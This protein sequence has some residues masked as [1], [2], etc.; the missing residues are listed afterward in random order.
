[1]L[2]YHAALVA[3]EP[4]TRAFLTAFDRLVRPGTRVL[5]VGSGTGVLAVAAAQRGAEVV[6]VERTEMIEYARVVAAANHVE[7]EWHNRDIVDLAD[8]AIAPVDVIVSE[9]IGNFLL[10]EDLIGV[11]AS[12]RRFLKPGG[13]LIPRRVRF[14]AAPG[15][16]RMI[17]DAIGFWKTPRFGIDFSPLAECLENS[18]FDELDRATSPIGPPI[19]FPALDLAVVEPG[20]YEVEGL[21]EI[22]AAA[23]VNS[24][25]VWWEAELA[26][27]VTLDLGP[28]VDWR[29][30]HWLRTVLPVPPRLVR[31]GEQIPFSLTYDPLAHPPLWSWSF[32]GASRSTFLSV[33]PTRERRVR[34]FGNGF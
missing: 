31:E 7:I 25:L 29:K 14:V 33:P 4:R 12:A 11:F 30:L 9:M 28:G 15:W 10:D 6:A 16:S 2:D 20:R 26:D 23:E 34:L 5:D 18:Y 3:D 1:M 27:G 17:D 24:V 22:N 21:L 8:S 19:R 13:A 32:D